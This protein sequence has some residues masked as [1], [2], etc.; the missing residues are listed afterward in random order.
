VST[1]LE[2]DVD[3]FV[4]DDPGFTAEEAYALLAGIGRNTST[5]PAPT[6]AAATTHEFGWVEAQHPRDG[7]G[8]FAEKADWVHRDLIAKMQSDMNVEANGGLNG[9]FPTAHQNALRSYSAA[10]YSAVNTALR[11]PNGYIGE[12]TRSLIDTIKK[13]MHPTSKPVKVARAIDGR[14]FGT[15]MF[16]TLAEMK[17]FKGRTFEEPGFMSTTTD[18]NYFKNGAIAGQT[19][20]TDRTQVRLELDV[21]AGTHAAYMGSPG[22]P[23]I[24]AES[25]LLLA[26][27]SRFTIDDVYEVDGYIYVRGRVVIR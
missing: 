18:Q 22:G 21:P 15:G 5:L 25:E 2:Q 23:G 1:S 10:A 7:E 20:T 11:T 4:V 16:P 17:K 19:I 26:P 24:F 9:D 3:F 12:R 13:A 8:K 6:T 27:G 14:A